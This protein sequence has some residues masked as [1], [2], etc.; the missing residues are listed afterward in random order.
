MSHKDPVNRKQYRHE[1]YLK[2]RAKET[3]YALE[4]H[5]NNFEK[6]KATKMRWH[7]KSTYGITESQFQ[8]LM[9]IQC[10]KCA[11]CTE[12]MKS[13]HVDHDH[14]TGR[15][16]GLLCRTCNVGIG[17]FKNNPDLL[18]VTIDYLGFEQSNPIAIS[19]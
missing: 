2:N 10:G 4:Y 17:M 7:R 8:T 1:Y 14:A 19:G 16:R 12:I 18:Q 13:P 3:L 5:K 9:L 11:I 15:V 6:I